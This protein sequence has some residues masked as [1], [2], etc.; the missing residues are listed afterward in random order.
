MASR[1]QKFRHNLAKRISRTTFEPY[2]YDFDSYLTQATNP[3]NDATTL[4]QLY[5]EEPICRGIVDTQADA[6]FGDYDFNFLRIKPR[7]NEKNTKDEYIDWTNEP[8]VRFNQK[9]RTMAAM[10]LVDGLFYLEIDPEAQNFYVLNKEDCEIR[11]NDTNTQIIGLNWYKTNPASPLPMDMRTNDNSTRFIPITHCVIASYHDPDTKYWQSA[12]LRSLIDSANILFHA[13]NYNNDIFR[14]GGMPSF[15][16]IFKGGITKD[17]FKRTVKEANHVKAGKNLFFK[18]DVDIKQVGGFNKDMEY[19]KLMKSAIQDFM[20]GMRIS[21]LMMNLMEKSGG[22][23]KNEF[24][25]F[26]E[27]IHTHQSIMDDAV[28]ETFWKIF[29]QTTQKLFTDGIQ[30]VFKNKRLSVESKLEKVNVLK[31]K[32]ASNPYKKVRFHL[33]KWVDLRLLSAIQKIWIDAGIINPNEGRKMIGLPPREGG[34]EYIDLNASV[35]AM[36]NTGGANLRD[37]AK[38]KEPKVSEPKKK[39]SVDDK[40]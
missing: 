38:I 20:T 37:D 16:Y 2:S 19:E 17:V 14:S 4:L 29:V 25:A 15:A 31:E 24:N 11:W 30:K 28:N 35:G 8:N 26:S 22:E 13:R 1:T 27:K 12:A 5:N 10:L 32:R 40:S 23:D 9:L 3:Y 18:A 21:P 33:R 36:G 7:E 6:I 34:D 39:P